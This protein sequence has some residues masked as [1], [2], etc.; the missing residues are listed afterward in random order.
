MPVFEQKLFNWLTVLI[1][2]KKALTKMEAA[3]TDCLNKPLF[4]HA[5]NLKK[6]FQTA[7]Y[8]PSISLG[9]PVRKYA[10]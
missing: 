8:F 1:V 6:S 4:E 7:S 5:G 3:V 2:A 9:V 10:V